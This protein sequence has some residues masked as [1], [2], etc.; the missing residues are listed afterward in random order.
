M[1]SRDVRDARPLPLGEVR[2]LD[3]G[4]YGHR[5]EVTVVDN[6]LDGRRVLVRLPAGATLIVPVHLLTRK[7]PT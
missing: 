5:L 7:T 4:D 2:I 1:S 3:L 6:T